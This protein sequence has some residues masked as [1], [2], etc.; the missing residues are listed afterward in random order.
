MRRPWISTNLALSADGKTSDAAHRP[1]GWTSSADHQRLVALRRHADA[2][3]VGHGT[4]KAD[5]MTLAVP[6]AVRQPLRCIVSR[7]GDI[8]AAHPVFSMPGGDIHVLATSGLTGSRHPAVTYHQENLPS[9]L[10]TLAATHGVRHLH[11]EGGGQL[12]AA[13]AALDF[14]DEFHATLAAHT[15]FGGVEAPTATGT[16]GAWLPESRRYEVIALDHQQDSGECFVTWRRLG[17][18]QCL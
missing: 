5:R 4:L 12:I 16:P 18:T 2:L 1:S 10:E 13:L 14:I 15:L 11:C 8:D 3:M 9:F 7:H 6:D 17:R